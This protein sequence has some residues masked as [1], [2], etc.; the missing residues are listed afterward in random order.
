MFPGGCIPGVRCVGAGAT[1]MRR[2][3]SLAGVVEV[4]WSGGDLHGAS[5]AP[6]P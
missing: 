5:N 1:V 6:G 2:I 3:S 4:T